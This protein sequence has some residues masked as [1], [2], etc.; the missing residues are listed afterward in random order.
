MYNRRWNRWQ[1]SVS[2]GPGYAYIGPCRCGRG[3]HAW[4]RDEKG[5]IIHAWDLWGSSAPTT[6]SNANIKNELEALKNEKAKLERQ[7]EE[8]ERQLK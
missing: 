8:L 4:Y 1:K 7:I 5:N 2:D 3:P 6:S